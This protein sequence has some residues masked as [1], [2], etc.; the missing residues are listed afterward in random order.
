VALAI[1]TGDSNTP[2][3]AVAGG[4]GPNLQHVFDLHPTYYIAASNIIQGT[5]A[6]METVT[7]MQKVEY[8][9]GVYAAAWTLTEQNI[10]VP[11]KVPAL[12]R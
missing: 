12:A 11:G 7:K 10:W 5:M 3:P 9:P 6:D 1:A 2:T 8:K 4:S